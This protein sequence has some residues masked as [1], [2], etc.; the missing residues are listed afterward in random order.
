MFPANYCKISTA[1]I[2]RSFGRTSTK[3]CLLDWYDCWQSNA[4]FPENSFQYKEDKYEVLHQI[5]VNTI[6]SSL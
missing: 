1:Y 6:Y 3:K 4:N 2:M 5:T